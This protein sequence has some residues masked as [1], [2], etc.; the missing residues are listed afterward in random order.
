MET[1]TITLQLSGTENVWLFPEEG[2]IQFW[3]GND[4]IEYP[5]EFA[6]QIFDWLKEHED[7]LMLAAGCDPL[8]DANQIRSDDDE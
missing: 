1:T 8:D 7:E 4:L 2:L 5:A 6:L 3:S